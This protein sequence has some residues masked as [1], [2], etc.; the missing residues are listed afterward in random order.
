[1][2]IFKGY[3]AIFIRPSA[4][5]DPAAVDGN[6]GIVPQLSPN[7]QVFI[8]ILTSGLRD[9]YGRGQRKNILASGDE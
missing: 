6:Y 7:C 4:N 3:S 8:N 1:M 2:L 9:L 5:K